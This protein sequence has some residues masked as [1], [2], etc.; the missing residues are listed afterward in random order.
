MKTAAVIDK[1][2]KAVGRMVVPAE[3]ITADKNS[4]AARHKILLAISGMDSDL[5]SL[6]Y[7]INVCERLDTGLEILYKPGK[8]AAALSRCLP[9]LKKR[10]V[11][12][13]MIESGGRL[14]D[15]IQTLTGT[16]GN[17]LFAVIGVPPGMNKSNPEIADLIN[18]LKCPLVTVSDHKRS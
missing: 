3:K 18:N 5:S 4:G 8:A 7:A 16:K 11:I 12:Y 14:T 15:E 1:N 17:V 13:S 10:G 2:D 6:K 9:E